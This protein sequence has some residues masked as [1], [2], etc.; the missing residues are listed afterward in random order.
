[1]RLL[2]DVGRTNDLAGHVSLG[3]KYPL[4]LVQRPQDRQKTCGLAE[5]VYASLRY[6][7]ATW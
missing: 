2:N 1:M 6:E 4:V 7:A 5:V 3:S